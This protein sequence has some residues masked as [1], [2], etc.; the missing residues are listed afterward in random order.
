MWQ[1]KVYFKNNRGEKLSGILEYPEEEQPEKAVLLLGPHPHLGGDIHNNVLETI[2]KNLV[3][4]I[5][6]RFDYHGTGASQALLPQ[7]I[8][9]YDH[10]ENL[11]Q[12]KDV[13]LFLDDALSAWDYLIS[14]LPDKSI[15]KIAI[16]Y[17]LGGYLVFA[18][19]RQRIADKALVLAPPLCKY[20]PVVCDQGIFCLNAQKDFLKS[21]AMP[22]NVLADTLEESDHFFRGH[23]EKVALW[24]LE[25]IS[26]KSKI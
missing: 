15:E 18:L 10:Y 2:A 5:T 13:S 3:Y 21:E 26:E 22:E 1:E 23:E 24:I 11:E 9:L 14:S 17:S 8:T 4:S 20:P 7:G 19:I 12:K 16:G 25:K 6:L